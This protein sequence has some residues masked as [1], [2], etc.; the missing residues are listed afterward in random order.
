M[1]SRQSQ[2]RQQ[3]SPYCQHQAEPRCCHRSCW[4]VTAVAAAAAVPAE[5]AASLARFA[6]CAEPADQTA[7]GC[8]VGHPCH[9][10]PEGVLGHARA[11]WGETAPGRG[12]AGGQKGLAQQQHCRSHEDPN[13]EGGC[14]TRK[15]VL[16]K[17]QIQSRPEQMQSRHPQQRGYG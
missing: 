13:A 14:C 12:M 4:P 8:W 3:L 17:R 16:K 7:A 9:R 2:R 5:E 11:W 15:A 1:H 6:R 10:K